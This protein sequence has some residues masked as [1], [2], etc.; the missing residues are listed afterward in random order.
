[1]VSI[2]KPEEMNLKQIWLE[3]ASMFVVK[4][5][6]QNSA[7]LW[8]LK[9]GWLNCNVFSSSID[10]IFSHIHRE[11]NVVADA[12]ARNGQSLQPLS[13]KWWKT[14]LSFISPLLYKDSYR[15]PFYRDVSV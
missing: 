13:S 8:C 6:N 7:V 15:L 5:F 1:M 12:L 4:A 10:C 14:P 3:S 9:N 2:E 11:G